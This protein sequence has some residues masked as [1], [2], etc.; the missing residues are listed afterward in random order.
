MEG[1]LNPNIG[2]EE[3]GAGVQPSTPQQPQQQP[4]AYVPFNAKAGPSPFEAGVD[5]A[6]GGLNEASKSFYEYAPLAHIMEQTGLIDRKEAIGVLDQEARKSF[7]KFREY[8]PEVASYK[9]IES[10][11]DLVTYVGDHLAMSAPQVAALFLGTT[12]L[13][14]LAAEATGTTLLQQEEAGNERNVP[15][16]VASGAFEAVLSSPLSKAAKGI[17]TAI[18]KTNLDAIAQKK[19][20]ADL[21]KG[22]GADTSLSGLQQITR[23][24]GVEG[25]FSAENLDEALV[26]GLLISTPIRGANYVSNKALQS[27]LINQATADPARSLKDSDGLVDKIINFTVGEGMRPSRRIKDVE[28]GKEIFDGVTEMRRNRETMVGDLNTRVD[29]VFKG[30]RDVA[31]MIDAYSRGD[32][33]TPKLQELESIFNDV[34]TRANDVNGANLNI[35]SIP[36][37]LPALMDPKTLTPEVVTSFKRD[38]ETYYNQNLPALQAAAVAAG[39]S[40]N[41]VITP[42]ANGKIVDEYIIALNDTQIRPA[43]LPRVVMDSQ[44]NITSAAAPINTRT[45]RK[46]N[47]LDFSRMLGHVPQEIMSQYAVRD[48]MPE[49]IKQYAFGAAQRITYAEQMGKNNEKLNLRVANAGKEMK[50]L[51]KPMNLEE[52][53]NIYDAMDAY[54]GLYGQFKDANA[55]KWGT[56]AR[57]VTNMF[58]LPLT[59]L[60][61]LTEPLNLAIKIG[62]VQAAKSFAAAM[63]TIS[64]DL[65]SHFTNGWV[66][67]SEINKQLLLADRSFRSGT[68][69][70]NNRINGDYASALNN[71]GLGTLKSLTAINNAYFHITGQT[72]VSYLVNSMSAHAANQQVRNDLMIVNGHQ[73]SQLAKEAGARLNAVG[74][75]NTSFTQLH[76]NPQLLTK[77]MPSV[78]ARFNRDVVLNPEAL[79][80]PL[81][82]STGWGTMFSQLRGYSTMFTNTVLPKFIDMFDV[83]GKTPADVT[84]DTVRGI[85]TLG[86]IVSLGFIQ[87]SLKNE[88]KGGTATDEELLFK[89]VQGTAMPIHMSYLLDA[90]NGNLSSLMSPASASISD[91]FIKKVHKGEDIE[92]TDLPFLNSYKGLL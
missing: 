12:G 38:Y 59:T 35:K 92:L 66:P 73:N 58:A 75:P 8:T 49:Q 56:R 14:M 24:Y 4:A 51:N 85:T 9:D 41:S 82:M 2:L 50:A 19:L 60:S 81:W 72:A 27:K 15:R 34:H 88:V 23:N 71:T 55:R 57:I 29:N 5:S 64:Q 87:E 28:P 16:A 61:S 68:T 52:M 17:F 1:G 86:T 6:W 67:K 65:I 36:N 89:A 80:K 32:R 69:A 22:I 10:G 44:G 30:E 53:N 54:Q 48:S 3:L 43:E 7:A 13:T 84:M 20:A 70:L 90:L 47:S 74:I 46:E 26:A 37:Y 18:G 31:G 91:T 40:P 77:E 78:V 39:K 25:E 63:G 79:D 45:V 11:G 21:I 42:H 83:R 62:G 76:L 33:S